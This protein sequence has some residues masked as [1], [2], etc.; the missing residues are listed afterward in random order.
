[1]S[2]NKNKFVTAQEIDGYKGIKSPHAREL[3]A[4]GKAKV[5]IFMSHKKR[6][7]KIVVENQLKG[8]IEN[9][10]FDEDYTVTFEFFPEVKVHI[11]FYNFEEEDEGLGGAELKVLY[12]GTRAMW[13]PT[14]D[15]VSLL[16]VTLEFLENLLSI[17]PELYGLSG[18]KTD[19]L[20]T[21]IEQRKN[22]FRYLDQTKL[23]D[24]ARFVG[25]KLHQEGNQ[26][27]LS[28]RY[29]EGVEVL[30][31]YNIETETLDLTYEGNNL[32]YLNNY[33]RD[34]LGIFLLNHCL[35]FI[36]VTYP[37]IQIPRIVKQ[38]FSFSYI[39]THNL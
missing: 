10:G 12:S 35:R 8:R 7:I 28:K 32:L 5:D 16:D 19:L 33:A 31:L 37:N 34:Q 6:Q 25:G 24:L 23:T 17:S 18:K 39:K 30:V 1:M 27:I 11:L 29:F 14:E 21:A 15:S 20:E 22:P 13:V 2:K 36:A 4:L 38:S 26:W 9:L 3:E